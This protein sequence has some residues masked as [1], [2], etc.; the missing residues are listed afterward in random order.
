MSTTETAPRSPVDKD[1]APAEL[2]SPTE[3]LVTAL[4]GAWIILGAATDGWAHVNILSNV[5]EDG[6]FTPWHALLYSGFAATAGW[7]VWLAYRRRQQARRWWIDGW[8]AGYRLGALGIVIFLVAG[9]LDMAWHEAFGIE[10]SIDALLSPSHL[11]LCAGS[12]LLLTSPVR[13]W[14]AAG[15]GGLRAASGAVALALGTTSASI[16]LSYVSMF[17]S[18]APMLPY[19]DEMGSPAQAAAAL[20]LASYIVTIAL[21]VVPLL[22]AH[23]RRAT[24]GVATALVAWVSLFPVLTHEFPRPQTSAAVA[25]I[26]AALLVDWTLVGMDRWRGTDAPLRLPVAGAIFAGLAS[27]AHLVALHVDSGIRWPVELWTGVVVTV[28]AVAA[29][30]GGLAARPHGASLPGDRAFVAPST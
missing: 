28:V 7:T 25:A 27:S 22:M 2:A 8:P 12:V 16:F 29:V 6:F 18:V 13:S 30:L 9:L 23:R 11:L 10:A 3:D 1:V 19:D 21:L 15:G 14:W 20:G 17:E 4:L 26:A 24:P 5:Q